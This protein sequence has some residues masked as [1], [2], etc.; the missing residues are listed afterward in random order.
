MNVFSMRLV[1]QP[2]CKSCA[3][4]LEPEIMFKGNDSCWEQLLL[5]EVLPT[6]ATGGGASGEARPG[7]AGG[8]GGGD[9]EVV[10]LRVGLT[11]WGR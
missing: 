10:K 3:K 11:R 4:Q 9:G 5:G 7:V 1:K 8:E 2:G 6:A